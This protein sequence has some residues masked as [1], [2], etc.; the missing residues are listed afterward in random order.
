[1]P[2][3]DG[4][5]VQFGATPC[6]GG[7]SFV[8][9]SEHAERIE[10]CLFD[11]TG[12]VEL[13]RHDMFGPKLGLFDGDL[14]D[15]APGL[16]YGFRA[17]GP[18]R[19]DEGHRFN[20]N[21]VLLDPYAREI[22]GDFQ[23]LSEHSG[24]V[25]ND[26]EGVSSFDQQDNASTALKA[27][28]P[29]ILAT[30]WTLSAPPRIATE[31]LVL[32][33]VHVKGFS[34]LHPEIPTEMRGTYSGLCHPAAIRHF[35]S[36]GV[37]ALSL[38]PIHYHIDEPGLAER[39]LI[40]YWGYNTLG[41]FCPDPTFSCSPDDPTAVRHEFRQMVATLHQ[42]G[43]EVILDV[44]Y[45]HTAEGSEAGPTLSFR[46]LDNA[47]W[48]HLATDD[49]S[50]CENISGCGNTVNVSH[51]RVTQFV[52]DSLRFWVE[53]MGVDGFRFDL[54]PVLG[55]TALGFKTNAAFFVALHQDPVLSR[56]H[57]IAEPWDGG[58]DGYQVGRFPGRFMEWND[59]FRDATRGYWLNSDI[60]RSEMACRL[61][62]SSD[63]FHHRQRQ[64]T[65]SVNFVCAHDGFT[66]HDVV[67]YSGKYNHANGEGNRD[68]RS[69][70]L[71]SNCGVEGPTEHDEVNLARRRKSRAMLMTLL[72]A[73]GTPMLC[74]GDELGRTQAGNNNAYCQDTPMSWLDWSAADKELMAFVSEVLA[75]RREEPLLR[76]GSWFVSTRSQRRDASAQWLLPNGHP[77]TDSDWHDPQNRALACLLIANVR[78]PGRREP[79]RIGAER[80]LLALNPQAHAQEFEMISGDWQLV[81]ESSGDSG[82]L[83]GCD[84]SHVVSLP[85]STM[86]V[87]RAR[88]C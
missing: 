53:E 12:R 87:F 20:P 85:A 62:A 67:R 63:L 33:E 1:M 86:A 3:I 59:K 32:Y 34:R 35:T 46:G 60:G 26:P 79:G 81:F 8:V 28:V 24:Y 68:G 47:S 61:L 31:N 69:D 17:Y 49:P 14:P 88:N 13:A 52:L 25:L 50:R 77:L 2:L 83:N 43:I 27:R 74:A 51:P 29:E 45:N 18:Y 82:I 37:N 78:E 4:R 5:H 42:H 56:V 55:R 76:H 40:N 15:G 41:F 54:A 6:D 66:L 21:K 16:I 58:P 19:P 22:V 73:Q 57:L 44:V 38:L 75:L 64:P 48:Y 72:L 11:P 80:I 71:C 39:G 65:A 70:E 9:F 84:V 30:A 36:L 23:W 10:L 7:V